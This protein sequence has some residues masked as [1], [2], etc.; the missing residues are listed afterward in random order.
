MKV[1]RRTVM[2]NMIWRF[3]ERCGAQG[4]GFVVSVI[5][6]RILEP[7]TYG[8]IALVNVFMD[9]LLVFINCGFGSALIQKK[10]PDD[11]DY[12]SVFYFNIFSCAIL[13]CLLFFAAPGI[14]LFYN[15]PDLTPLIRVMGLTLI[16]SG[17]KNIQQSYVSKHLIFKRFF[18]ATLGGTIGAA[19]IGISMA[20]MGFGVW[21]LVV[22]NLFNTVV[23]T[24]ILW[25]TV[26]WRPKKLF[27]F[28]RLKTLFSFGWKMLVSNLLDTGYSKLTQ[29]II[30]KKYSTADLAFYNRGDNIPS[31]AIA[32][33][34][35]SIDSVLMPSMS[36]VQDNQSLLK[37]MV[38]RSIKTS[39]YLMMPIMAGI[40]ACA[41]PIVSLIFTD[42]W[43]PCV[44]FLRIFCFTY[45]F[46]PIHT[47]N[48]NAIK[49]VGRSDIFLKLEILKKIIGLT[50]ILT[51]MWFGVMPMACSLLFTSVTSQI[52]NSWP[53]KKILKYGYLEQL[54]D[55]MPSILLSLFMIACVLPIQYIGLNCIITLCIQVP[56]G[57]LIYILGSKVLKLDSFD[58]LWDMVKS[59]FKKIIRKRSK[60]S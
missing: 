27:S 8:I 13:Y 32:N 14:A 9:I 44:P 22:Q 28:T 19:V 53:N 59:P 25:I 15:M 2:S 41:E 55:I 29:L 46:W 5:L 56:L 4:V 21:A 45:A 47:A 57:V 17:V 24:I 43:L 42:K 51:T 3:M 12:S 11:I 10:E 58:Y 37:N 7:S 50:A 60:I 26:K 33:I 38:R 1:N 36:S 31:L 35:N 52:I 39:T 34:N 49:A 54:R 30:G 18:F 48:L 23:D 40:A 20:L 6:A 16:V